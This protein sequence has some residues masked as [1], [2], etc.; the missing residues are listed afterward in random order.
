LGD[1]HD[2][3]EFIETFPRRGYQFVAAVS[4]VS[5]GTLS[6]A[7]LNGTRKM[8]GREAD[9]AQLDGYQWPAGTL[10]FLALAWLIHQ[11]RESQCRKRIVDPGKDRAR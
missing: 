2:K 1:R 11:R 6:D 9:M 10:F 7:S 4:E 5:P 8:V 3:P